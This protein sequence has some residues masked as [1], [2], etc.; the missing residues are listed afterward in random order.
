MPRATYIVMKDHL[1]ICCNIFL[2]KYG[3]PLAEN[4]S[5]RCREPP[6]YFNLYVFLEQDSPSKYSLWVWVR[7]SSP[8]LQ[9]NQLCQS[10]VCSVTL[11][12]VYVKKTPTNYLFMLNNIENNQIPLLVILRNALQQYFGGISSVLDQLVQWGQ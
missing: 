1:E 6:C 11:S 3:A 8:F 5:V 12:K 2:S 9:E 7:L 10:P 4:D